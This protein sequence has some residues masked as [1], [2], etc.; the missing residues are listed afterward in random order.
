M[1]LLEDI[2]AARSDILASLDVTTLTLYKV[3]IAVS[4]EV[5]E[6]ISQSRIIRSMGTMEHLECWWQLLWE[7][8]GPLD[9]PA[10]TIHILVELPA[11][12][13]IN[14]RACSGVA[15]TVL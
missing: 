9:L 10:S 14:A 3:N 12:E 5:I 6:A 4:E 8:F 13:S 1:D 2:K 7:L 11:S 15:E